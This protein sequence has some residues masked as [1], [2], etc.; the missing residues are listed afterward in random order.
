MLV[1]ETLEN[2]TVEVDEIT[3]D[4][5]VIVSTNSS[6][7]GGIPEAPNDGK[8]YGRK[9]LGWS[10]IEITNIDGGNPSSIYL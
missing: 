10:E 5:T 6:D 9:D 7:G 3:E 4:I 1:E 2:I 8:L